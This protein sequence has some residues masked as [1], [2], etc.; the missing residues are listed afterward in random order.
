MSILGPDGRPMAA[1][2]SIFGASKSLDDMP[3]L[4]ADTITEMYEGMKGILGSGQPLEVPA[5]M[6]MGQL[7]SIAVTLKRLHERVVELEAQLV[8]SSE[9]AKTVEPVNQQLLDFAK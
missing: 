4:G 8:D 9:D 7:A 3:V 6:P 1:G 5:A 2:R